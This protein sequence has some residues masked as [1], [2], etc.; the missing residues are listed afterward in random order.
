MMFHRVPLNVGHPGHGMNRASR[1][2]DFF[3]LTWQISL[4]V[5]YW[6]P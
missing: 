3:A 5:P 4:M 6:V 1:Y 2:A